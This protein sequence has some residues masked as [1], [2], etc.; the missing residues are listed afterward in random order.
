M[1]S[2]NL[3]ITFTSFWIRNVFRYFHSVFIGFLYKSFIPPSFPPPD[4]AVISS[5]W[6][7]ESFQILVLEVK[8]VF[9]AD[10]RVQAKLCLVFHQ[11]QEESQALLNDTL[12][13]LL[14][15]KCR[16]AMQ[17]LHQMSYLVFNSVSKPEL[18]ELLT[19][20]WLNCNISSRAWEPNGRPFCS[21]EYKTFI[22]WAK[23]VKLCPH[24]DLKFI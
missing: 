11:S 10:R 24:L 12:V 5:S 8:I 1:N 17:G 9:L 6:F 3:I 4:L 13:H 14:E 19:A 16:L 15:F 22:C 23:L 21:A 7:H 2:F 20:W 18:S